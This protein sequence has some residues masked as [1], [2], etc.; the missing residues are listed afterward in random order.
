VGIDISKRAVEHGRSRGRVLWTL[1]EWVREPPECASEADA[2]VMLDVL[3]HAEDPHAVLTFVSSLLTPGGLLLIETPSWRYPLRRV[4]LWIARVTRGR[5]DWARYLIYP[6]HRVYFTP[7][8]LANLLADHGL[9]ALWQKHVTSPQRKI[10]LKLK[11]IHRSGTFGLLLGWLALLVT[12]AL[13]GNKIL[14]CARK[15]RTAHVSDQSES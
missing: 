10:L 3:E 15:A 7:V 13:G 11:R 8:A 5:I 12:R 9:C 14:L 2:V 1:E 6:D 4:S